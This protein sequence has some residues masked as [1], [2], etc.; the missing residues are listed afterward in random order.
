MEVVFFKRPVESVLRMVPLIPTTVSAVAP[1]ASPVCVA[2]LTKPEYSEFTA[3]S[4]VLVPE[5]LATAEFASMALVIAP[6]AMLVVVPTEVT[7][8]VK[9]GMEFGTKS[10]PPIAITLEAMP[11]TSPRP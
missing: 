5:R 2:L 9:L 4:P 10:G 1:V 8:P 7:T 6:F 3:L 11:L